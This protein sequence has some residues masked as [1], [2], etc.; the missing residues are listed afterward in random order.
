MMSHHNSIP[1][2][3]GVRVTVKLRSGDRCRCKTLKTTKP[4]KSVSLSTP[5]MRPVE[6]QPQQNAST[7]GQPAKPNVGNTDRHNNRHHV[8]RSRHSCKLPHHY[9]GI[10]IWCRFS[11]LFFNM[12]HLSVR[13]C[14]VRGCNLNKRIALA[15]T[16]QPLLVFTKFESDINLKIILFCFYFSGIV[17]LLLKPSLIVLVQLYIIICLRRF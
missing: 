3:S 5:Q 7:I 14:F 13:N 16:W 6:Q 4:S 12:Q 9:R 10:G 8:R 1:T 11:D 15:N 17:N 2:T